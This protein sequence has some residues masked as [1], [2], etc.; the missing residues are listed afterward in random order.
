MNIFSKID[1]PKMTY[2]VCS[3][4]NGSLFENY[5]GDSIDY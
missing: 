5:N 1:I 3:Q 4:T 2:T